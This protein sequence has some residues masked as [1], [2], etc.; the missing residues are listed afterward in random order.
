MEDRFVLAAATFAEKVA[1]AA[2]EFAVVARAVARPDQ[3]DAGEAEDP[4]VA[5]SRQR[6]LVEVDGL[7]TRD[8]LKVAEISE[9]MGGYDVANTHL[10]LRALEK[11]AVV[12][13]VPGSAPQR[14]RLTERY[15]KRRVWSTQELILAYHYFTTHGNKIDESDLEDLKDKLDRLALT[16]GHR[17]RSY[18]S[19][20]YK[21]GNFLAVETDGKAGFPHVGAGDRRVVEEFRDRPADL[22]A[23]AAEVEADIE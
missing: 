6:L 21:L 17:G 22:A 13:M 18:G 5:G 14:W 1:A 23:A 4:P 7:D 11:K 10:T 3:G 19:I 16:H 2:Q 15:R 8:G 20:V 9:G 12:E